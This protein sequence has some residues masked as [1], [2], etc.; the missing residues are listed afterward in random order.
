MTRSTASPHLAQALRR[1][2]YLLSGWPWRALAYLL[3]TLPVAG[4]LWLA[5]LGLAAS[6]VALARSVRRDQLSLTPPALLC[7]AVGL[8]ALAGVVLLVS[9]PLAALER[10]RLRLVDPRRLPGTG[11]WRGVF[12]HYAT[13]AGWRELGL[14][15][16]LAGVLPVGYSVL[17]LLAVL[18]ATLLVSPFVVT[19]SEPV[20][21]LHSTVTT[22]GQAVP[23]AVAALLAVPLLAYLGGLLAAGQAAA[24]RWILGASGEA[25]Q[26]IEVARSRARLVDAYEAER[27]RI[28]RD[29]HDA[30]QP[31]L[32]SL[33]LQLGLARLDV[34]EDSPAARPLAIAHEQAKGLM[35]TLREIVRGIRPQ[36]L[37]DAGLAGAVRELA[38]RATVTVQVEDQL[39]GPLPELVETTAYYVVCEALANVERHAAA[40]RARV[41]LAREGGRL[42][43]EVTDDGHG[44]ADPGAGTGLVGLADRVAAVDGRL[45]LSSPPGGPTRLRVELPCGR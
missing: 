13:A 8:L 19:G 7:L 41:R 3:G 36:G 45:L 44:G 25:A 40:G 21:L 15:C 9:A 29:V 23:F 16:F 35:V 34:P 26:L 32:T 4:P 18:D 11:R 42:V 17:A 37:A 27:H 10:W 6:L 28:G 38:D 33:T 1:P 30:A 5:A 2:G 20:V 43:V 22:R 24:T 14:L 39:C 12:G 31:R